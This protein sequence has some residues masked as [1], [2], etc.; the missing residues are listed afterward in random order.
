VTVRVGTLLAGTV[1]E[2]DEAAGY[3][4]LVDAT[5][6]RWWFHCTAI[7]DGSR[8]IVVG[9]AVRFRLQPGHLGRHE[10]V[11]VNPV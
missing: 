4:A 2:Y 1:A 11:D 6:K 7:V 9:S 10:A 5:G 3:G 8:S